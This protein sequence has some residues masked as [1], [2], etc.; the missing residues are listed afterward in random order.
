MCTVA[1]F[2]AAAAINTA[3]VALEQRRRL[4]TRR[5]GRRGWYVHLALVLPAWI[6]VLL[7]VRRVGRHVRW[8]LPPALQPVGTLLLGAAGALWI[9]AFARLG[10]TRTGN[11]NV[12]G[13]GRQEPV[14]GG[15][16][17]FRANPMYDSYVLA[18]LG[19]ALRTGN[20]VYLLL[21]G[22]ALVLCHRIE[23]PIENRPL[24]AGARAARSRHIPGGTLPSEGSHLRRC[25]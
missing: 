16:F 8:P 20:A 2:A 25:L 4:F 5:F 24:A 21:A 23:A 1:L 12:F 6:G 19:L 22:E 14:T 9:A 15:V 18:L 3:S 10:P 7:Q 17:R 11:G 13:H